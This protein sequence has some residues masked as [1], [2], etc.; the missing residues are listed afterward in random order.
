S[1]AASISGRICPHVSAQGVTSAGS[2]RRYRVAV[3][4][5]F[6]FLL[7]YH[8][9]KPRSRNGSHA[10]DKLVG[11]VEAEI[12]RRLEAARAPGSPNRISAS[13]LRDWAREYLSEYDDELQQFPELAGQPHTNLWM[14]DADYATALFVVLVFHPDGLEFFCGHGNAYAIMGFDEPDD[15]AL[16]FEAMRQQFTIPE[17]PLQIGRDF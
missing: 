3:V 12:V 15:L 7:A 17:A 5:A 1:S 8:I 2:R 14:M 6:S 9:P 10:M 13:Q 16:Y 4:T 11:V